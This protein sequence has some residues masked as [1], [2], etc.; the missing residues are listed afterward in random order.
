MALE[1]R[2]AADGSLVRAVNVGAIS[3]DT[4]EGFPFV[5]LSPDGHAV[6]RHTSFGAPAR[7]VVID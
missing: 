7:I 1:E 5:D 3:R 4:E 2:R 6:L